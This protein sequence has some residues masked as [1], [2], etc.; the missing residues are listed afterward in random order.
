MIS[1][2]QA[3]GL[4][5]LAVAAASVHANVWTTESVQEGAQAIEV[6]RQALVHDQAGRPH[7]FYGGS[8]LYH[9]YFDGQAWQ[10]EIVDP[11]PRTGRFA[12]AA[13]GP[14]GRFH[15]AYLDEYSSGP[16]S[17]GV[18]YALGSTGSWTTEQIPVIPAAI[19]TD[20][21]FDS[22]AVDSSGVPYIVR[23]ECF[24]NPGIQIHK[25]SGGSWTT[26]TAASLTGCESGGDPQTRLASVVIDG[27]DQPHVLYYFDSDGTLRHSRRSGGVWTGEIVAG[28]GHNEHSSFARGPGDVLYACYQAFGQ[29]GLALYCANNASGSWQ[30]ALVDEGGDLGPTTR[31]A[32]AY[33]SV[34]VDT[35]GAVHVS[36]YGSDQDPSLKYFIRYATNASG[37]WSVRS[38]ATNLIFPSPT[39]FGLD[40][41][42]NPILGYKERGDPWLYLGVDGALKR[43]A[44]NGSAWD[45]TDVDTGF[46]VPRPAGVS[47]SVAVDATGF[48]HA[49]YL[50]QD[51]QSFYLQYATN[52]TGSWISEKFGA[53]GNALGT[54]FGN[55]TTPRVQT[56][57]LGAAHIVFAENV[58]FS[59]KLK[60]RTNSTG[61][62][63]ESEI[64]PIT[65]PGGSREILTIS[66]VLKNGTSH[67]AF[68]VRTPSKAELHYV[69]N[70]TGTWSDLMVFDF[71]SENSEIASYLSTTDEVVW[72]DLAVED[73]G[74][75]DILFSH[76][77]LKYAKITA[78][79]V[80][81]QTVLA[82]KFDEHWGRRSLA[83]SSTGTKY[84]AVEKLVL[85]FG[86]AF[87]PAGMFLN[88]DESGQWQESLVDAEVYF[89]PYGIVYQNRIAYFLT[90]RD[91]ALSVKGSA[92]RLTYYHEFYEH[93]RVASRGQCGYTSVIG[94]DAFRI[95][96]ELRYN[97]A[98]RSFSG[99]DS[100]PNGLAKIVYYD[101]A[102][103]RLVAGQ[104]SPGLSLCATD[105]PFA[106][107]AVGSSAESDFV[108]SNDSGRNANVAPVVD[109]I[110]S[111]FSIVGDAC[112]GRVLTPGSK[113][114]IRLKFTPTS[115]LP[116]SAPF[117]VVY[118]LDAGQEQVIFSS[119]E[120]NTAVSAPPSPPGGSPPGSSG[121]TGDNGSGSRCFIA[122]A[123]FGSPLATE[124]DYLRKFRDKYLMVSSLGRAFVNWYYR[125]SP[126]VADFLK[127]HDHVRFAVRI[128]LT[129]VVESIKPFVTGDSPVERLKGAHA[130]KGESQAQAAEAAAAHGLRRRPLGT[131]RRPALRRVRRPTV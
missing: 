11:A 51:V 124:V 106:S 47:P 122:T 91:P 79:A 78:G 76:S 92:V 66:Y 98:A 65:W 2:R 68:I 18:R 83:L 80:S 103:G 41:T 119:V 1:A 90:P 10:K 127:A 121:A 71:G 62:W 74:D 49:V 72:A 5:C 96:G 40:G 84:L 16:N 94:S 52:K 81:V 93:I 4:L 43:L 115:P 102:N 29:I 44:W 3:L 108:V 75:V 34:F 9:K 89:F 114:S 95:N 129:V 131:V 28:P 100:L 33:P 54:G 118:A 82:P 123:A 22:I 36:Y 67:I 107:V 111:P 130:E 64:S 55:I 32:G 116:T 59:S 126:P 58:N 88:S 23:R 70:A 56:D 101:Q 24:Q 86:G 77:D 48:M 25:K 35:G 19:Y 57:A 21:D 17:K 109:L 13:I 53:V 15:V 125:Y 99:I 20:S 113:C 73:N 97:I 46:A 7:Y 117:A 85:C 38:V 112:T 87:C 37:T 128:L 60:Y 14:D 30:R 50:F 6:S 12:R 27:N 110:A 120:A 105:G 26:E 31:Q 8:H 63:V 61:S 42:G 45:T 69:T 39:I 104:S